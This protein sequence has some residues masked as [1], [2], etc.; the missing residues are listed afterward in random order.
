V[1]LAAMLVPLLLALRR[2]YRELPAGGVEVTDDELDDPTV[3]A[4]PWRVD[5]DECRRL[6]A[7]G[8]VSEALAALH[9]LTLLAL[10]R[11]GHLT[12]D[13]TTTNWEYVRQLSSKPALRRMLAAVTEGAERAVLGHRPPGVERYHEL[14][15]LV[16][17]GVQR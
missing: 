11:T 14:E 7:A 6:V 2:G 13:S 8:R 15:G 16:R 5:L 4:A 1:V 12:L 10:E 17:E 9:R 3:V